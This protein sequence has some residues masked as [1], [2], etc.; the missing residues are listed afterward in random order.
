MAKLGAPGIL[1]LVVALVGV[2]FFILAVGGV[3]FEEPTPVT[4]PGMWSV[5]IVLVVLGLLGIWANIAETKQR[6]GQ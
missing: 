6:Q 4:D 1:S 2:L 3:L 5:T